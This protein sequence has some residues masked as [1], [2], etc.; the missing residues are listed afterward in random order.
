MLSCVETNDPIVLFY[1]RNAKEKIT[2]CKLIVFFVLPE[3]VWQDPRF[4]ALIDK[5]RTSREAEYDV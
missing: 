2:S 1:N 4:N 5:L 3:S